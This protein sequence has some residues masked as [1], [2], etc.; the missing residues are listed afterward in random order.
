MKF[1]KSIVNLDITDDI[2]KYVTNYIK[3]C[4]TLMNERGYVEEFIWNDTNG[5]Y[6]HDLHTLISNDIITYGEYKDGMLLPS[7]PM[8]Y[9]QMSF[10]IADKVL[11]ENGFKLP[12]VKEVNNA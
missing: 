7:N 8:W 11:L 9:K 6:E 10:M 1:N 4:V 3:E 5:V 12:V 2:K